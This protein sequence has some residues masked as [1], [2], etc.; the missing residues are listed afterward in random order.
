M[1][2]EGEGKE[3]SRKGRE[4]KEGQMLVVQRTRKLINNFKSVIPNRLI[5]G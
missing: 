4:G 5:I 2:G 3:G 1:A